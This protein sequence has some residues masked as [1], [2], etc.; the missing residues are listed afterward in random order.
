MVRFGSNYH[1]SVRDLPGGG[2]VAAAAAQTE[3][4]KKQEQIFLL[5]IISNISAPPSL[6]TADTQGRFYG[7]N[8]FRRRAGRRLRLRNRH[9]AI[10]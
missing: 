4:E 8:K 10:V 2:R 5:L 1:G 9:S 7:V 6:H 3:A